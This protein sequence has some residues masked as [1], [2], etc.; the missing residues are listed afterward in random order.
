M[1]LLGQILL[2]CLVVAALQGILAVLAVG[3]VL[4]FVIG[5]IWRPAETVPL[6]L[7][8]LLLEALGRWPLT[9]LSS[10]A[11]LAGAFLIA[12]RAKRAA[13][14]DA[15]PEPPADDADAARRLTASPPRRRCFHHVGNSGNRP[16][17]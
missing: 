10:L 3:L 15:T 11:V 6:L 14:G 17:D 12:A 13:P 8:L 7:F 16:K 2:A 4:A 9:T 5:L 1:N